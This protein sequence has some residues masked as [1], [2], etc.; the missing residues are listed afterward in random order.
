[1]AKVYIAGKITGDPEYKAKFA[2]VEKWL[3]GEGV[4]LLSPATL[5]AGM[6]AADYMRICFAMIDTAD[7]VY[8]LPDWVHSRGA[9]V[10]MEYCKYVRKPVFIAN[11]HTAKPV[12]WVKEE[13]K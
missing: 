13:Q 6:K 12:E 3:T 1:M 10:E 7:L 8:F 9:R 2:K 11:D 4:V 5:P